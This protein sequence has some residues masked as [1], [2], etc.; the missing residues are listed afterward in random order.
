MKKILLSMMAAAVITAFPNWANAAA[1]MTLSDGVNP[2]VIVIDNI[3]PDLA[4]GTGILLASTTVG[5]W[6]VVV[7]GVTKPVFGSA[8]NP[9]MDINVQARSTDAGTL[10]VTFSDNDFG[11]S[12]PK[13]GLLQGTI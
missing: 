3:P 13:T 1:T 4:P 10:T 9:I 12:G 11:G 7:G 5:V 2:T 8:S 6:Q